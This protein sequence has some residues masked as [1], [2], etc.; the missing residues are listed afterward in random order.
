[1]MSDIYYT[2]RRCCHTLAARK[3]M[4][5]FAIDWDAKRVIDVEVCTGDH[6]PCGGHVASLA[7]RVKMAGYTGRAVLDCTENPI[8]SAN[9]PGDVVQTMIEYAAEWGFDFVVPTA[10]WDRGNHADRAF[11]RYYSEMGRSDD[12]PFKP[13]LEVL[14]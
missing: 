6:T 14:G 2:W 12:E 4:V 13:P 8:E 10:A 9:L 7:N 1:M 11:A 5:L 3:A